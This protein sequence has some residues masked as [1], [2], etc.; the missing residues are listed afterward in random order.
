MTTN[1]LDFL[2]IGE[3]LD[4]MTVAGAGYRR[5]Q[6]MNENHT[7]HKGTLI[8]NGGYAIKNEVGDAPNLRGGKTQAIKHQNGNQTL[9]MCAA[10][11]DVA[12]IGWTPKYYVAEYDDPVDVGKRVVNTVSGY[13]APQDLPGANGK[14][15]SAVTLFVVLKDDPDKKLWA[16]DFRGYV[17]D[18]AQ[19]VVFAAKGLANDLARKANV[20]TVHPFAHWLTLAVGEGK[21][22]GKK[23]QSIVSPPAWLTDN[24]NIVRTI[25]SKEDYAH[26]INLRREL[27]EYLPQSKYAIRP[28]APALNA[29]Q[30][31]RPALA[32]AGYTP[33][34]GTGDF[35]G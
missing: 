32:P 35:N 21:M 26:F 17:A 19:K 22:V 28:T 9:M 4:E 14:C 16:L 15:R 34:A 12:L 6:H 2:S 27:D 23:E 29:P 1:E 25:V 18:D 33:N 8:Q 3:S 30:T 31:N 20:K 24:G 11:L 7:Y 10:E 13:I 5:I